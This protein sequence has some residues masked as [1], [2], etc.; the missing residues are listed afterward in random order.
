MKEKKIEKKEKS[1]KKVISG[2]NTRK[3][4]GKHQL[5]VTHA[6]TPSTLFR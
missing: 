3:K 2:Q 1:K 4:C 5:P 6:H